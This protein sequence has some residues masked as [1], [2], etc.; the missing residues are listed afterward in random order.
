MKII[1]AF[2][3]SLLILLHSAGAFGFSS[4]PVQELDP[5]KIYKHDVKI[6]V[7]GL[8]GVGVLVVPKAKSYSI[9][10]ESLGNLDLLTI[11]TCHRDVSWSP[12]SKKFHY[13]YLPS[14][15]LEAN[16]S[17]PMLIG[18]YDKK[19]Q[20][21]WAFIDFQTDDA[22]LPALLKCNGYGQTFQ[23][24]SV[25]QSRQTL[26]QFIEFEQP[27]K[28]FGSKE[29]PMVEPINGGKRFEFPLPKGFCVF[30]FMEIAGEKRIHRLST[31]GYES[32]LLREE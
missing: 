32:I 3:Y 12:N 27:V 26:T 19:G 29:C 17:C 13:D 25:C 15:S 21:G 28:V 24:V 30:A 5:K 23:G 22:K 16:G 7:N 14:E 4:A 6:S 18:A 20:H 2:S 11:T 10:G 1:L 9:D 31:I 8:T